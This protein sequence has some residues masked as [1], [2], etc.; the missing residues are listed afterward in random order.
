LSLCNVS[1]TPPFQNLLHPWVKKKLQG[2]KSGEYCRWAPP[3]FFQRETKFHTKMFFSKISL[4]I[5][6]KKIAEHTWRHLEIMPENFTRSTQ[7]SVTWQ[8]SSEYLRL[9]VP[10]GRTLNYVSFVRKIQIPELFVSPSYITNNPSSNA[11]YII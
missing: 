7:R 8:T 9:T 6:F 2:V 10:S 4:F 5:L 11:I 3:P 1:K